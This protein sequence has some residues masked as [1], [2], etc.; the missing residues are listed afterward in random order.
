MIQLTDEQKLILQ[1]SGSNLYISAA[2]GSGKSTLLSKIAEKI[3][4]NPENRVILISFTNK[5]AESITAKCSQ[6]DK[7]RLTS[8][9]FHSIAYRLLKR[10]GIRCS[11]CDEHKKRLIIKTVFNCRKDKEKFER[12]YEH[13][14][15]EK[16]KYPVVL[17]PSVQTYNSELE[18]YNLLD[19]DDIIL[20]WINSTKNQE[21]NAN[22]FPEIT[23]CLVDEL[24]DTSGP[25]LEMLKTIV[26]KTNCKIIGVADDDQCQ[27][28]STRILTT[29]GYKLISQIDPAKDRL[30][31]F[32]NKGS[33]IGGLKNGYSFKKSV[34]KYTGRIYTIFCGEKEAECTPNHKWLVRWSEAAKTKYVVYL[35]KKDN[36]YRVGWCQLFNSEGGL[37]LGIRSRLENADATWILEVCNSKRIASIKE[38]I[39]AARFGIPTI[40]FEQGKTY[41]DKDA[42]EQIYR[43][44]GYNKLKERIDNLF[45]DY[46]LLEEYPLWTRE[47]AKD[48]QGGMQRFKVQACNIFATLF[49]I[50]IQTIGKKF[51]WKNINAIMSFNVENIDVYSLDVK[52]GND[53]GINSKTYICNGGIVTSNS[54]YSWRG[55]RPENVQDF[56]KIF[57]C[58]VMNMGINF[59]SDKKIVEHATKL[60]ENN[61]ER[62]PKT[63]QAASKEDG[64][65][66]QYKCT[67]PFDQVDYVILKCQQNQDK[68]I[69][70]LYRNRTFK[71]HLEFA[72]R[73]ANLRYKVN[74]FLDITDRSAVRVMISCL[75]IASDQYDIFDLEQ[76]AK[77]LKGIGS[78]GVAKIK[79]ESEKLPFKSVIASWIADPKKS[80]KLA[81]ITTL[82]K[83]F[84]RLTN[85]ALDVLVRLAENVF[86]K[87]F[88]YQ[89]EMRQFLIDI[90]KSLR[91]TKEDVIALA[92]ELGLNGPKEEKQ[93]DDAKI[94][95]STVHGYKGAEREVIIMPWCEQ[96]ELQPN[97]EYDL[98]SERR[99][100]YVGIT[101]AKSKLYL[102]YSNNT[103]RF[104]K[105]MKL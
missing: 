97:K 3:L 64:K 79:S 71:Y 51:E 25:Q 87:S 45:Y 54:I 20:R 68:E 96:Y 100:F 30:P 38:S 82:Q 81:S 34:R 93:D 91:I 103:P 61:K 32:I 72:L 66:F 19:F 104:I 73:K 77:A 56:I 21:C 8:G 52:V 40:T 101:R 7:S 41:Y 11:I 75:K 27:P 47:K 2:P 36:K 98:E 44:I 15:H 78:A 48:K 59:R 49:D 83:E 22:G 58:K 94:E 35:M 31:A 62:I 14:S 69:A 1:N 4:E 67:N 46:S 86:L 85:S 16:S 13:I 29:S 80:K 99:L 9:T 90:T 43:E 84:E 88:D 26:C 60:I 76:A 28:S 23:H 10:N 6:L 39:I 74:D 18:K 24:Q 95:L 12:L 92:N 50:P 63:I 70:V 53:N 42:V 105:E 5:A 57:D 65:V 55:A 17:T 102:V 89:D 33:Y 37:H